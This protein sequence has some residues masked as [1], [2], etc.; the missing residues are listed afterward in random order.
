MI[1]Q[2]GGVTLFAVQLHRSRLT[3]FAF[4]VVL[5]IAGLGLGSALVKAADSP[6][7]CGGFDDLI[8]MPDG[9]YAAVGRLA[10]PVPEFSSNKGPATLHRLNADGSVNTGFGNNGSV[11]IP[12][13]GEPY[14]APELFA[15]GDKIISRIGSALTRFNGDGTIDDSFGTEGQISLPLSRDTFYTAGIAVQDDGKIVVAGDAGAPDYNPKVVRYDTDGTVD[16]TFAGGL[17]E[18]VVPAEIHGFAP[19]GPVAIDAQGRVLVAGASGSGYPDRTITL[20]RLE[21]DGDLDTGFG[22]GGTGFA[23]TIAEIPLLGGGVVSRA[24]TIGQRV[25]GRIDFYWSLQALVVKSIEYR[26]YTVAVDGEGTP[27]GDAVTELKAGTIGD[28]VQLP[29]GDV[30][31]G[32]YLNNNFPYANGPVPPNQMRVGRFTSGGSGGFPSGESFATIPATPGGGELSAIAYDETT[33]SLVGAGVA[34]WDQCPASGLSG[35][36]GEYRA[37]T[38]VK[39]AAL[40]GELD[41]GFGTSG[42]AMIPRNSCGS[43]ATDPT[44]VGQPPIWNRCVLSKPAVSAKA[45]FF[46]RSA[47]APGIDLTVRLSDPPRLPALLDR[48]VRIRLPKRLN[49]RRGGMKLKVRAYTAGS[50]EARPKNEFRATAKGRLITFRYTPEVLYNRSGDYSFEPPNS[51]LTFKVRVKRGSLKPIGPKLRKKKLVFRTT[52]TNLGGRWYGGSSESAVVKAK[53]ARR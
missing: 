53:P 15:S 46:G 48:Q 27:L 20:M 2:P 28:I 21:E 6:E 51:T 38:V 23:P 8:V 42:I 34:R 35:E 13:L 26:T 30:A 45:K 29:G 7:G 3:V 47:K 4:V 36:C 17:A 41:P 1:V 31:T 16:D 5:A 19:L 50:P 24:M 25:D 49:V 37:A 52:G 39:V 12:A 40:T 9:G 10:C 43:A 11:T 32:G 14:G 22:P 44:D 18:P 33:D